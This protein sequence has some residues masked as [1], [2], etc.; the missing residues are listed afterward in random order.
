MILSPT[1]VHMHHDVLVKRMGVLDD[2]LA[3]VNQ[4]QPGLVVVGSEA[5][6][7][8]VPKAGSVALALMRDL[9]AP[10]LLV[11]VRE[12]ITSALW[13]EV[14]PLGVSNGPLPGAEERD[15]AP[16]CWPLPLVAPHSP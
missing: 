5:L 16:A 15:F 14:E 4:L 11:K 9:N 6:A 8:P 10:M 1:L 13:F 3:H 7:A 2:I 12:H